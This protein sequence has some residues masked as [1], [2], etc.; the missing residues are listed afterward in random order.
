ML[1][2]K[3]AYDFKTFKQMLILAGYSICVDLDLKKILQ[4]LFALNLIGLKIHFLFKKK[5]HNKFQNIFL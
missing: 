1:L 5:T 4:L 3:F 2:G